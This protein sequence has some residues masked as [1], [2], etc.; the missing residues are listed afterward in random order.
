MKIRCVYEHNGDDTILYADNFIGAYT[1]GAS[2]QM[3]M[4]KMNRRWH[5]ILTGVMPHS[6]E[7][8]LW[9]LYRRRNLICRYATRI[10]MFYLIQKKVH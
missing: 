5:R 2:L 7:N 1:R 9:K 8:S 4:D 10:P 6:M 3:A